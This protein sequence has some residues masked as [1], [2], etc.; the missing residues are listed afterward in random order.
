MAL[1][2]V[3]H[4]SDLVV[5][6]PTAGDPQS[7]GDDHL[8]NIKTALKTDFP[9]ITGAVT[10]THTDLNRR[11]FDSAQVITDV[12]ATRA[13]STAYT[14]STSRPIYVQVAILPT[15]AGNAILQV[16]GISVHLD[17]VEVGKLRTLSGMVLPGVTYQLVPSSGAAFTI[18]SWAETR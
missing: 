8:R 6:N 2:T 5:T 7:Q 18:I 17:F 4:I 11:S 12:T 13:V 9:N 1:E 15:V 10:A 3:T 16:G 14:N